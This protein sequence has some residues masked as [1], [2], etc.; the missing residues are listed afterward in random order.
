MRPT[1]CA[2]GFLRVRAACLAAL[3]TSL[4][5][6]ANAAE[7]LDRVASPH[8][9]PTTYTEGALALPG[10]GFLLRNNYATHWYDSN[11]DYLRSG[12]PLPFTGFAVGT[13]IHGIDLQKRPPPV[14]FASRGC[15][16]LRLE[17]EVTVRQLGYSYS[18]THRPGELW[19]TNPPDPEGSQFG[20]IT[21][22]DGTS[23]EL[24]RIDRD[25]QESLLSADDWQVSGLA[26]AQDAPGAFLVAYRDGAQ[27]L[28]RIAPDG[29][30]VWSLPLPLPFGA[31]GKFWHMAATPQGVVLAAPTGQAL[32]ATHVVL[33]RS[34]D[35]ASGWTRELVLPGMDLQ[36]LDAHGDAA[37]LWLQSFPGGGL[38]T[39]V[40][41]H[42]SGGGEPV[43]HEL[44]ELLPR[45][46]IPGAS[47][48][49]AWMTGVIVGGEWLDRR[50]VRMDE[51][52]ALQQLHQLEPGQYPLFLLD[53]GRLLLVS[54]DAEQ[55]QAYALLQP[56]TGATSL[57]PMP[58]E[59]SAAGV[60]A[61]AADNGQVAAIV[62][63]MVGSNRLRLLDADG[64]LLWDRELT[65][66]SIG[67]LQQ[68]SWNVGFHGNELCA[69]RTLIVLANF[70]QSDLVCV[71]RTDGQ[72]MVPLQLV[73]S[74]TSWP[75]VV[76]GQ[77]SDRFVVFNRVTCGSDS[78][79]AQVVRK[80]LR[81]AKLGVAEILLSGSAGSL[82]TEPAPVGERDAVLVWNPGGAQPQMAVRIGPS[83]VV[84][85][86][87]VPRGHHLQNVFGAANGRVLQ[88][89][90]DDLG[91]VR[92]EQLDEDG[93]V[94]WSHVIAD[95]FSV[96]AAAVPDGWALSATGLGASAVLRKLGASGSPQWTHPLVNH[97]LTGTGTLAWLDTGV[98][99]WSRA[100]L[101]PFLRLHNAEVEWIDPATGAFLGADAVPG[102][103]LQ[104]RPIFPPPLV[105]LNG[106]IITGLSAN[107]L[108]WLGRLE[109]PAP[110]QPILDSVHGSWYEPRTS[111][112]GLYL[113]VSPDRIVY[114]GWFTYVGVG[115]G[116]R[117]AQ[118]WYTLQGQVG[119]DGRAELDILMAGGGQFAA[120]PSVGSTPVGSASLS[121]SGCNSAELRYRF[122]D[123]EL[124]GVKGVLAV[125]RIGAADC[126]G[127]PAASTL[128]RGAWYDPATSGQGLFFDSIA[129]DEAVVPAALWF[130]FDPAGASDDPAAQHW[131]TLSAP[132]ADPA[133]D[134]VEFTI[135]RTIGALFDRGRTE[136]THRVGNA[137]LQVTSC[138]AVTLSWKFDDTLL[139][140]S[141]AGL[142]GDQSLQSISPCPLS[143]QP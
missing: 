58:V 97:N 70:V 96:T 137:T 100:E 36:A 132:P 66:A 142:R 3:A 133:A 15:T 77:G 140:G 61:L 103:G 45:Q 5:T 94:A 99:A 31:A 102:S 39:A 90:A 12:E 11:G 126:A 8:P 95:H 2:K 119:A 34:A 60:A 130:T 84:W 40:A 74:S 85:A 91:V 135:Y 80:E 139:A 73:D 107:G 10:G 131:F 28:L 134:R 92:V 101:D 62:F 69:T 37:S 87:P 72:V 46:R 44:L 109:P 23:T 43:V 65:P 7:W 138:D 56:G 57:L 121:V 30:T 98:L 14:A 16:L 108:A 89:V 54:L 63:D 59:A 17:G 55:E 141:F 26:N 13:G 124:A 22:D 76:L 116:D 143:A 49:P 48:P 129:A 83:G 19:S 18:P 27:Q 29:S 51:S 32:G 64:R 104:F 115:N 35:G 106:G 38:P 114:G 82:A 9:W 78:C 52:G 111:G 68:W 113:G 25:C 81:G 24:L 4:A 6:P 71:A 122:D 33:A 123:T 75:P 118:R 120:G 1:L 105:P 125:Q 41:V 88:A 136:N 21:S 47:G 110:P 42:A 53:D 50:V 117:S 93:L 67:S 79:A 20:W 112:Q 86:S 128:P 127:A